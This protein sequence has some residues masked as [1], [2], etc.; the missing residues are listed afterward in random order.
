M[1]RPRLLRAVLVAL[2]AAL[3]I[4][5]VSAIGAKPDIFHSDFLVTEEDVDVCGVVVDIVNKGVFTNKA[6]LDKQGNFVRFMSTASAA[7]TPHGRERQVG[8]HPER[9]AVRG[10]RTARG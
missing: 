6:F 1:G 4:L 3:V 7:I 10:R 5:P 8:D 9:R 2:A